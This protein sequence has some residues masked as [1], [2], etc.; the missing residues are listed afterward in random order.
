[1]E[2]FGV[3]DLELLAM[4]SGGASVREAEDDCWSVEE[5]R[6]R[7]SIEVVDSETESFPFPSD[8]TANVTIFTP[9]PSLLLAGIKS[10]VWP[11]L[12]LSAVRI[13]W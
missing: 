6:D 2:P 5:E 7:E 1:M 13:G 12:R 3:V 11:S 9:K 10:V 4:D 8:G